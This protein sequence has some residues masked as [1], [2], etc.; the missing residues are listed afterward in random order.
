MN[1]KKRSGKKVLAGF[2]LLHASPSL[3]VD[4]VQDLAYTPLE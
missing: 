2:S 4:L 3:A 1:P